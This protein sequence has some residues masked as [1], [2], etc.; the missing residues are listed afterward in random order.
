[1]ASR[2]GCVVVG[3]G[4]AFGGELRRRLREEDG[5]TANMRLIWEE[6]YYLKIESRYKFVIE[7]I[8]IYLFNKYKFVFDLTIFS[9][10]LTFIFD[11]S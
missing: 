10:D 9:S 6:W 3:G 11:T 4:G 5:V 8:H 2:G 1:M 7:Y